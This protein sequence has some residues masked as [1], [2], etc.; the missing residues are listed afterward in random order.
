MSGDLAPA[1]PLFFAVGGSRCGPDPVR[2]RH[3]SSARRSLDRERS[4]ERL[5]DPFAFGLV[6]ITK[7]HVQFIEIGRS[8]RASVR[9]SFQPRQC[10]II[11]SSRSRAGEAAPPNLFDDDALA[12]YSGPTR[13]MAGR[14]LRVGPAGRMPGVPPR[15]VWGG[16]GRTG[17]P[18][19]G[20]RRSSDTALAFGRGAEYN[21]PM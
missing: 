10:Q 21:R 11:I 19:R 17:R 6:A 8:S 2:Q 20:I 5:H 18:D 1:D 15:G 7:Q 3:R 4:E 14:F 13:A 9:S 12:R 16:I